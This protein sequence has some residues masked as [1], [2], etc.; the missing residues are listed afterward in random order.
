MLSVIAG[1]IFIIFMSS[2]IEAAFKKAAPP[3][4]RMNY[5]EALEFLREKASEFALTL[6]TTADKAPPLV[7]KDS[8]KTLA[9]EFYGF[10]DGKSIVDQPSAASF[11]LRALYATQFSKMNKNVHDEAILIPGKLSASAHEQ[12]A[13]DAHLKGIAEIN[14]NALKYHTI[15]ELW[16]IFCTEAYQPI[17]TKYGYS[18]PFTHDKISLDEKSTY[19]LF[20]AQILLA[21][22]VMGKA[23]L[24]DAIDRHLKNDAFETVCQEYTDKAIVEYL[25]A[26]PLINDKNLR[27]YLTQSTSLPSK[28]LALVRIGNPTK[29]AFPPELFA[30][31]DG[32]EEAFET[33]PEN[34]PH[35]W[36]RFPS[37]QE[38]T[39]EQLH[40]LAVELRTPSLLETRLQ[41]FP[42][43]PIMVRNVSRL[44]PKLRRSIRHAASYY[45]YLLGT[46]TFDSPSQEAN[47]M[48]W[49]FT[50]VDSLNDVIWKDLCGDKERRQRAL[51]R[52]TGFL[53]RYSGDSCAIFRRHVRKE[54][55]ACFGRPGASPAA[56]QG[57]AG[58]LKTNMACRMTDRQGAQYE[59]IAVASDTS[60][61]IQRFQE[62]VKQPPSL[63]LEPLLYDYDAA[64]AGPLRP[65]LQDLLLIAPSFFF[66]HVHMGYWQFFMEDLTVP[67]V[68]DSFKTLVTFNS[69]QMRHVIRGLAKQ[70]ELQ[71]TKQPE[72]L[73]HINGFAAI[74]GFLSDSEYA[75]DLVPLPLQDSLSGIRTGYRLE[76]DEEDWISDHPFE[77]RKWNWRDLLLY[78]TI[79][80]GGVPCS[81]LYKTV[82]NV[83]ISS[84]ISRAALH[85]LSMNCL[86]EV[87]TDAYLQKIKDKSR[88][89]SNRRKDLDSDD[90][91][92]E[93]W[94]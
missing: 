25:L 48:E 56:L 26:L 67:V 3:P 91:R 2:S 43:E 71:V 23:D 49:I 81:T 86:V 40:A 13:S 33:D 94:D 55:S 66:E 88:S 53:D 78:W 4:P 15:P 16:S 44:L 75:K 70:M 7:T 12:A 57:L 21:V 74:F 24:K 84:S 90:D 85:D 32:I 35:F 29:G 17:D 59:L 65:L 60:V 63:R 64:L 51:D 46:A 69:H 79:Q 52:F 9:K 14:K 5:E 58:W 18:I 38:W 30:T 1:I 50:N 89:Y 76:G 62:Y 41:G 19:P 8:W 34:D 80:E 36:S 73:T 92:E 83:A 10:D 20:L 77:L 54:L 68:F 31:W 22:A 11:H 87:P 47:V 72:F 61:S 93:S 45:Q 37:D 82:K 6:D 39:E 27:D 42:N 28:S